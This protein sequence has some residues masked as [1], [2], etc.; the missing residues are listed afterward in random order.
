[1]RELTRGVLAFGVVTACAACGSSSNGK[2][3]ASGNGSDAVVF[4]DA[5]G[6]DG[7]AALPC[8]VTAGSNVTM[9]KIGQIGGPAMLATSPPND[10][11]LFV[12]DQGGLI[13]IFDKEQLKATPFLDITA[14]VTAGGEQGLLG[15]AF[16]PNYA[17]NHKF[18]VDYTAGNCA[19]TCNDIVEEYTATGLE[20]ADAASG[21][22]ILSIPDFATNHNAGMIEFGS[23]GFLYV[24]TG[25]GGGGGDPHLNGQSTDRTA[26]S[27]TASGCEPLLGKILRLDVNNP[28]NGKNYGIPAGNPFAAGGGEPEI[29]LW[30]VRNPWRWSFDRATGDMWIGDVGQGKIEEID[31]LPAGQQ[32]GKNLGWSMWEGSGAGSC[33]GNYTCSPTGITFPQVVKTHT[34]DGW[35][36]IIGG[37]VYRG[38]CYPD[39][40]GFYFYTDNVKHGISRGHLETDGTVTSV[41]LTPPTGGF[42]ASPSSIHADSRGELYETTTDGSVYHLEAGP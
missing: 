4:M 33:Y 10:G 5:P 26:A 22:I 14:K 23:D 37:Q 19:P 25:D 30:G 18:Y 3:D 17:N 29:F 20:T 1:M 36:A 7:P 6:P 32:A 41:D 40:V 8:T 31:A 2:H 13:N 21:K 15:L 35:F 16:H 9:R 42:P 12:I 24:S 38:S 39:L 11:R 28:A 34:G 27:C